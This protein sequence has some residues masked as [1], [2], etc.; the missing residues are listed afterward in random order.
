MRAG[1]Q[2]RKS[3]KIYL[4]APLFTL[5]ERR[6]NT[7]LAR[8]LTK[9]IPRAEIILPQ[10]RA[11]EF[12]IDGKMDFENVVR[13]CISAID[14]AD[15]LVAILDGADSD[16]GTS[17]ECGYAY[18][19]RKPI[20]GVRTDLR[21]SEDGGLNAMLQRTCAQVIVSPATRATVKS[22]A[23]EIA[24]TLLLILRTGSR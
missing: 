4:A 14:S 3:L 21:S 15:A 23:R 12:V 2:M 6:L 20:V 9:L 22:L 8:E 5:A 19:C 18:A 24:A 7:E 10:I 13:D 17:W 16:S 1:K 11:A